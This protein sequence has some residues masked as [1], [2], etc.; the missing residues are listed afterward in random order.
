MQFQKRNDRNFFIVRDN[1]RLVFT[2]QPTT[3]D[4]IELVLEGNTYR[5]CEL[6]APNYWDD[7]DGSANL[8]AFIDEKTLTNGELFDGRLIVHSR[9]GDLAQLWLAI[10]NENAN[11]RED[12]QISVEQIPPYQGTKEWL[13]TH[14]RIFNDSNLAAKYS[15]EEG[16]TLLNKE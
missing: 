12:I 16:W 5:T 8:N 7:L 2:S 13:E 4:I 1:G 15:N 14:N 10:L 3:G 9:F 11:R 6:T